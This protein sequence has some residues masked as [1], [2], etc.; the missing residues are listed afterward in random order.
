MKKWVA[1]H[2]AAV[3]LTLVGIG[4]WVYTGI[5][6]FLLLAP[7]VFVVGVALRAFPR[8]TIWLAIAGYGTLVIPN[9]WFFAILLALATSVVPG[10][11]SL[12]PFPKAKAKAPQ[13]QA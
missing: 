1:N 11:R 4:L 7:V 12:S 13:R 2:K 8:I 3:I 10:L 9:G 5:D 6:Y